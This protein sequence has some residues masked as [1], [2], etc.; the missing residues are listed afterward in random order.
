S[1]KHKNSLCN[2]YVLT[3]TPTL[4]NSHNN[5][6]TNNGRILLT[7]QQKRRNPNNLILLSNN[8]NKVNNNG[9]IDFGQ[10]P[11]R[12]KKKLSVTNFS[13]H[14]DNKNYKKLQSSD[15]NYNSS[16]NENNI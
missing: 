6:N 13:L 15:N 10:Q 11:L 8:P 2:P 1:F 9:I 12:K 3:Q 5:K 4:N 7:Q 16:E 14:N